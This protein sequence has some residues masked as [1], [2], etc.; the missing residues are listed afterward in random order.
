[1]KDDEFENYADAI[2]YLTPYYDE[3]SGKLKEICDKANIMK[4][5]SND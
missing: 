1:M 3:I 2:E 5:I 4:F